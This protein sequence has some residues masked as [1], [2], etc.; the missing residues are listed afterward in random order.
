VAALRFYNSLTKTVESFAPLHNRLVRV[1]NC[2]P[3]VYKR[4]HIGNMRRFLFSDFLRRTLELFNYNVQEVTNI[5]DVGHLTDDDVGAGEDK[6]EQAAR[7]TRRTPQDIAREQTTLFFA[8]LKALNIQPAWKYPLASQHID[9]M[10]QMISQ[11]IAGGHGY[12]TATGV[13]FD[14]GSFPRYGQLSGNKLD[15]LAAGHRV[16][17]REEKRHPADFAL[18]V[19][20]STHLQ[21]WDSPWGVGYPGWHIECSAMSLAY[22]GPEIDIHTG[23]EDNR[24]PH[25]ENEIAQA[26]AATGKLFVR[27]WM[28]NRHLQIGGK[29]LA[30]RAGE[31]ITLTT[32][33]DRGYSPLAFR[34]LVFAS[35]YRSPMDFS[36]ETLSA[37]QENLAALRQLVRR[38]RELLVRVHTDV[39]G[40]PDRSILDTFQA[41]LADDLN[42]PAALAVVMSYVKKLNTKLAGPSSRQPTQEEVMGAL[43]TLYSLDKVLGI[44]EPL[45]RELE[46]EAESVPESLR[47]LAEQ[48]ETARAAQDFDLADRLRKEIEQAGFVIEDTPEGPRLVKKE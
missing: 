35:H 40:L 18:W 29:K 34:L 8:D 37:A 6:I 38:L 32:L 44:I 31:Q 48:R 39:V 14:V 43:E 11:L 9:N 22:L 12:V 21:K 10:Q 24:F 33:A 45:E 25:H 30:K 15:D 7:Q 16:D 42:T 13:Y 27:F 4:Q 20:D 5:T 28:H 46:H 2:G 47:E 17:V 41:A 1:Y 19:V 23:G 26:E 36:W 3:T